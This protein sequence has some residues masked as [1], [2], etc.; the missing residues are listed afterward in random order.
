[1]KSGQS[2]FKIVK[3]GA[4]NT[5]VLIPG[6]ATDHRVYSFLDLDYN[7]IIATK[8]CIPTFVED[9]NDLLEENE[10]Q[11]VSI[12]GYSLGGF[13]AKDFCLEF[14]AKVDELILVGIR[15]HYREAELLAVRQA[16][17]KNRR[18]FL[19]G[20]YRD[21]FSDSDPS[22]LWFKDNLLKNYLDG[23]DTHILFDGL[24]YLA[25]ARMS[26]EDFSCV[27]RVVFFHGREDKIAPLKEA[28][29]IAA[30]LPQASF[31]AIP[32]RGHLPFLCSGFGKTL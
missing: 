21:C 14:G 3:R 30:F 10:L 16:L 4:K 1:M 6:W 2:E 19:I 12:F 8:I 32:K 24:D 11:K 13:L 7:Y 25:Q 15:K 5:L 23:F 22:R 26:G 29:G 17:G 9:L 28:E 20:F 27:K 31:T 18:A